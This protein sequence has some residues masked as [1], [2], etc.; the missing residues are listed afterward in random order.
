[1]KSRN[2][3]V[4]AGALVAAALTIGAGENGGVRGPAGASVL[5]QVPSACFAETAHVYASE[6]LGLLLDLAG[7]IE[8]GIR[9][10]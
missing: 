2:Y 1:M 9:T 3:Q 5:V 10:F 8:A 4:M 7:E 6:A